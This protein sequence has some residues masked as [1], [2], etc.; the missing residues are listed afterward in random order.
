MEECLYPQE[1]LGSEHFNSTSLN[2]IRTILSNS[3]L[4]TSYWSE[5][6]LCFTSTWNRCCHGHSI[7]RPF[8]L[9]GSR[10]PSVQHLKIFE[11]ITY[12]DIP[13]HGRNKLKKVLLI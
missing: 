5:A 3:K 7:Q 12:I 2:T 1:K 11:S 9:Y 4:P 13:K 6:L 10:K 8:K